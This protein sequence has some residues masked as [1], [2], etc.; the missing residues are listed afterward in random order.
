MTA[1]ELLSRTAEYDYWANRAAFD[2]MRIA[3]NPDKATALYGHIIY[4]QRVWQARING[5]NTAGTEVF[6]A[7]NMEEFQQ[8]TDIVHSRWT[9]ILNVMSDTELDVDVTYRTIAGK[10]FKTST[11]DILNHVFLHSA[12]HRGQI[13]IILR[14]CG[15]QPPVTDFIAFARL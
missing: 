4:A 11:V 10:E 14:S 5:D 12:Y 2:A 8:F 13:A 7:I 15:A 9:D 1:K 6:P 3:G